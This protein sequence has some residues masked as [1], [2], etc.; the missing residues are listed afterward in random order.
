[1]Q[2]EA[3]ESVPELATQPDDEPPAP[4]PPL[5]AQPGGAQTGAAQ[6][7]ATPPSAAQNSAAQN[8][9]PQSSAAQ[10][11]AAQSS[12]APMNAPGSSSGQVNAAPYR[13]NVG[14]TSAA[15]LASLWN[16]T[17][18]QR[19]RGRWQELQSKFLDD[20]H[21]VAGEAERLVQEAVASLTT[22]LDSRRTQLH[23]QR[24][25]RGLDTE[26]LRAS[27]RDYRE[28]LDRILGL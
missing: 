21:L 26:N 13:A 24:A 7:S 8:S 4:G 22:S 20:P 23:Q 15:N 11:S 28:F 3:D 2:P 27:L 19:I 1:M 9:A 5:S 17:D 14:G 18:R 16:D 6:D 12:A 25:S 10:S